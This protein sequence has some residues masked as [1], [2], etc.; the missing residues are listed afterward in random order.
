VSEQLGLSAGRAAER[1]ECRRKRPK[2][3]HIR[4]ESTHCSRSRATAFGKND[5][6]GTSNFDA[7]E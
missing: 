2:L 5:Q 3:V 7:T 4:P 6:L 1:N